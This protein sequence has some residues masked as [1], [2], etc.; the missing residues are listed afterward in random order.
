MTVWHDTMTWQY[1]NMLD[2]MTYANTVCKK[3]VL[4]KIKK[5]KQKMKNASGGGLN[6]LT[7]VYSGWW[8]GGGATQHPNIYNTFL[9]DNRLLIEDSNR[10][11]SHS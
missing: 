5:S 8:G 9:Y 7:F 2:R 4:V 1:A 6:D 10:L 3:L 11:M